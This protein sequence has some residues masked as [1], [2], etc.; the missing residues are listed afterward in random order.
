MAAEVFV[1]T[2]PVT[3]DAVEL[4]IRAANLGARILAQ[5]IDVLVQ[6]AL[7]AVLIF[8]LFSVGR[9][10]LT[11]SSLRIAAV[12]VILVGVMV[13]VPATVETLTRGKSLGKYAVGLRVVRDDHG[14]I[15]ARQAIGRALIGYVE[16]WMTAG[17][18]AVL[19]AVLTSRGKRLGDLASG[20]VVVSERV[21]LKWPAPM[22]MP[23]GLARWALS[24]DI[25]PLDPRVTLAARQYLLRRTQ[26]SPT[27]R[28]RLSHQLADNLRRQ[29]SPQPPPSTADDLIMAIIA[30]R[31]RRDRQRLRHHDDLRARLFGSVRP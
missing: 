2:G 7:L 20:T 3:G 5:L 23:P 15:R 18:P 19:S 29:V 6:V 14:T 27:A 30:E 12:I 24:A 28:E 25:G 8:W 21:P 1:P 31:G 17:V 13:V 11:D 9:H 22:P 10:Q 4:E 16:L 26:L